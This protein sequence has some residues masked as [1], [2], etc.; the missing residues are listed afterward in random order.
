L[1]S[2][3]ENDSKTS[4]KDNLGNKVKSNPVPVDTYKE[5]LPKRPARSFNVPKRGTYVNEGDVTYN[6]TGKSFINQEEADKY[7]QDS[8]TELTLNQAKAEQNRARLIGKPITIDEAIERVRV[9]DIGLRTNPVTGT[10]VARGD[11]KSERPL[12]EQ[13]IN[14]V[15][16]RRFPVLAMQ[17]KVSGLSAKEQYDA[18]SLPL[19]FDAVKQIVSTRNPARQQQI[20]NTMGPDMQAIMLDV[21]N[22]WVDEANKNIEVSKEEEGQ[23]VISNAIGF[24]WDRSLGPIFDGLFWATERGVQAGTAISWMGSGMSPQEAWDASQPGTLDKTMVDYARKTY[25]DTVVDVILDAREASETDNPDEAIAS[26]LDKY[27]SNDDLERLGILEQALNLNAYDKNTL[28]AITYLASAET[29]NM[30]NIFSWSFNS[31]LGIDPLTPEGIESSQSALF[32]GTRN[33]INTLALFAFDPLLVGGKFGKM[34]K[35]YKYGLGKLDPAIIDKSF[36]QRGVKNFFDT[37]GAGLTKVDEAEDATKAAQMMNSLRSQYKNFLNADALEGF[38]VSG[39]RSSEDAAIFFKD[40]QN[41]ELMTM[42]QVAKRG[43]QVTIPHMISANAMV[44]RASL[45]ARGLTYDRNSAKNIDNIFGEGVSQMLP[46]EAIPVI[47]KRLSSNSGDKFVGRMLSDFVYANDTAKRTFLGKIVNLASVSPR[48]D[49]RI[50]YAMQRYGFKRKTGPRARL[51]RV[52]RTQAHMPDLSNGL[53]L[54]S[55]KDAYKIRDLMLYGGMPKYWADYSAEIWRAMNPGQRKEFASGIG[56]S[57][58]Y[59]L[60]VDIID[61][62][63]GTKLIDNVVSGMRTGELY[64]PSYIDMPSIKASVVKQ[65]KDD[66]ENQVAAA[67]MDAPVYNPSVLEDGSSAA[68][69]DYQMTS[70]I[71][72]PNMAALDR[73]SLRQSYL[74]ALLGDNGKMSTLTDFWALGTIGGPRF[75]LRNGLEDAGL[76]ALTGGSWKGY[77][78]GQL[79]S[80]AKREATQRVEKEATSLVRGQKLGL[81]PSSTRWLGDQMPRALQGIILPH[82]NEAEIAAAKKFADAGEREPLVG[83]IRKAF[84]RQKLLFINKPRNKQVIKDLDEAAEHPSFYTIM[85]EASETTENLVN[86]NMNAASKTNKAIINGEIQDVNGIPLPYNVKQVIPEDVESIRA[87]HNNIYAVLHGDA[88]KNELASFIKAYYEAKVSGS[89]DQIER[90]V[91]QYASV[92]QTGSQKMLNNSAIVAAEGVPSFARRKLDDAL[93]VFTTK[94]GS[95]N[96]DLYNKIRKE[97]VNAKGETEVSYS[98]YDIENGK[99]IDR[100]TEE[101]LINMPGKPSLALS[102]DNATIPVSTK[103]PLRMQAWSAMGRSLARFTR[104]PIFI[105]NYLDARNLLRPIEERMIKE[106]GEEAGKNWAVENAY[107]RAFA[108][109]MAYVD[110]PEVRSQMAWNVRNIARFYRAQEDFFRRMMRTTRNNPLAIQRLNI[111]WHALDETGFTSEDEYGDKYFIWPGNKVTLTAI[112]NITKLFGVNVLEGGSVMDFTSKVSMLTPSGDPNS[113]APTFAGPYGATLFTGLMKIFPA[114][115][116]LQE[117]IMG[118]Y[119]VGRPYWETVIPTNVKKGVDLFNLAFKRDDFLDNNTV[120]ADSARSAIQVYAATGLFD[121]TKQYSNTELQD[122]KD[123]LNT[124]AV[125]ITFLKTI[126]GPTLPAAV[127]VNPQTV[128]DFAKSMGISGMRKIFI[129]LVKVNDGDFNQAMIK[130][131]KM[132]PGLSIFTVSEND[133]PD[134]FG[135]FASTKETQLFIENNKELFDKSKTG[136]AF[137]APQ[138]G[139]Q[140]LSAWKYLASMGAKIPK[141]VDQYF[142]EMVTAE[143]YALYR[144]LQKQYYDGIDAGD[145]SVKDKWSVAKKILYLEYPMLESRLQGDLS[146]GSSPNKTDY[147]SDIEDIRTAVS[148]MKDNNKL[149]QR[150][151]DAENIINLYDEAASRLNSLD[152]QDPMY[153]KNRKKIKDSWANV[154]SKA[155]PLY[156]DDLQWKLLLNATSGALGF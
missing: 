37:L 66:V 51:E 19:A 137:F 85:D 53:D 143:G 21:Y 58:G 119:S 10:V 123:K 43:D 52:A 68:L 62:V 77:R 33:T 102:V 120:F 18:V 45:V 129:E 78:Y 151:I 118:E 9:N 29:G 32:T 92:L 128:T 115:E 86:G 69:Y 141:T 23:N 147:R 82:L 5:P 59:S 70:I 1:I 2:P 90:V 134:S 136:A 154:E 125:D 76:Y 142:N 117:E 149:D 106:F 47:I 101:D 54:A 17:A 26:L 12:T 6:A 110:N 116:S 28:D 71:S 25:G 20:I 4:K 153:E 15:A 93:R 145:D 99:K 121:E 144:V 80:K 35:M 97:K 108:T 55:S 11:I 61:P 87:W 48:E 98:M 95:F 67:A 7:R 100:I 96:D 49:Q 83:L 140:S 113:L 74:T 139:V 122:L 133:N 57:V 103:I 73:M 91:S 155:S 22:A 14:E 89:A 72:F 56:R 135:N 16:V 36:Q 131:I 156:T 3:I 39:I 8:V 107:E 40:A 81:I 27:A 44:K 60:G 104:E 105:A 65:G 112:N 64:S 152:P 31:M 75:F 130:W 94:D 79:Y 146:D 150:G 114:L 124:A 34:Y 63:S 84:M 30:G 24:V 46:E 126:A 148:W 138:E 109:T 132:N 42:G 111:G 127:S 88:K 50:R 41:I 13:E 38:K